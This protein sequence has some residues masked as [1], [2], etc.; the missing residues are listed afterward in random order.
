MPAPHTVEHPAELLAFLFACRPEVKRTKVRQWLKH[1]A[2]QVNGRSVTRTN[3]AL[4]I[5]DVVSIRGKAVVHGGGLLPLGMEVLFED[6][7]LLVIE[8][9]ENLLSMASAT[10]RDKNV[11]AVLTDYVRHGTVRGSARVWIVHRLDRET[12]GVMVFAK[13]EVAKCALQAQWDETEKRYLAVVE[14]HP[15]A[16]QGVLESH[17][18]ER[19]PFKVYSATASGRTRHA[20]TPYRV[21][22][23]NATRALVAL[24]PTTGRRNQLRVHLADAGCPIVGDRKYA[25][26]TDPAGRLGLHA[27]ALQFTHPHSGELVR[28][29][30]PLP[31]DLARLL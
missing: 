29:L 30:S 4:Q 14:G 13:T 7:S 25:A 11:Y 5:G 27:E 15:P 18:D 1:G 20:I 23:R 3:H 6:A 28:F 2:V 17:L 9:P 21:M 8:K 19:G 24:T 31:H 10:E 12:S 26:R 22:K 16:D